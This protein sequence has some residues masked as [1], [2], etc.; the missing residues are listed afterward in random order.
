MGVVSPLIRH[1]VQVVET[2]PIEPAMLASFPELREIKPTSTEVERDLI[3][4]QLMK[5]LAAEPVAPVAEVASEAPV[6]PA[7][8]SSADRLRKG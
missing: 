6:A 3:L 8:E 4:Q 1:L 5:R 7:E 2:L